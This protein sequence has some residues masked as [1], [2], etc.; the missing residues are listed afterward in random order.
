MNVRGCNDFYEGW[1]SY[2]L[3]RDA[4]LKAMKVPHE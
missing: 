2:F 1:L 4:L 3:G